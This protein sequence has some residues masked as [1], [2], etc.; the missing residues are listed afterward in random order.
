MTLSRTRLLILIVAVAAPFGATAQEPGRASIDDPRL[1]EANRAMADG[2]HEVALERYDAVLLEDPQRLD[3]RA[4]RAIALFSLGESEAAEEEIRAIRQRQL[5]DLERD[6][7]RAPDDTS[8][9]ARLARVQSELEDHDA[10]LV[11]ARRVLRLQPDSAEAHF[12]LG[13]VLYR[14]GEAV[15]ALDSYDRALSLDPTMTQAYAARSA[16]RQRAGNQRGAA[17]DLLHVRD[18]SCHVSH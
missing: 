4:S 9:L 16:A 3:V 10:A 13:N 8:L 18:G 12:A 6:L 1:E 5:A 17:A 11:S 15:A 2:R 7:Q 14:A